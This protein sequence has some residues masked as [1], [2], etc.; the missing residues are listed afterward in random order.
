MSERVLKYKCP[1]CDSLAV[2]MIEA[3]YWNWR[4]QEWANR[5]YQRY[6]YKCEACESAFETVDDLVVVDMP[7]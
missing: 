5:R 1:E 4:V 3:N 2:Y 6:S 7:E